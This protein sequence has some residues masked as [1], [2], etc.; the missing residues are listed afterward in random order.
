MVDSKTVIR[1][2]ARD[3]WYEVGHEGSHKHFKHPTKPG[4]ATV[5]HPVKDIPP[6]TLKS[7]ERLTGL[8]FK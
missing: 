4:K 8:K 3:D 6:K 5:V 1:E 2:M 7:I